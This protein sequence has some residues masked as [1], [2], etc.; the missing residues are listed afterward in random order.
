MI[1]CLDFRSLYPIMM[2]SGNLFTPANN[3]ESS[4]Q[5]SGIYA[6]VYQNERDGIRGRYSRKRGE[7]ETVLYE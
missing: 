1:I 6:S 3:N 5:G 7:I 2:M 4:W